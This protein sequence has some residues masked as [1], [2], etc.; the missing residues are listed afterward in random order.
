MYKEKL[1][2]KVPKK[3]AHPQKVNEDC[4]GVAQRSHCLQGSGFFSTSGVWVQKGLRV[5]GLGL[6]V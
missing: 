1:P 3:A 4:L 5:L 6:R 2:K